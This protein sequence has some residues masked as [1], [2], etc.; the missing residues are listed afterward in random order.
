[1]LSAGFFFITDSSKWTY[2]IYCV[3]YRK[4]EKGRIT[5]IT[6][7]PAGIHD[8]KGFKEE[9][10]LFLLQGLDDSDLKIDS[11]EVKRTPLDLGKLNKVA[12]CVSTVFYHAYVILKI[13]EK[14]HYRY[15]SL[16]KHSD[17]LTIQISHKL[18]DV[19]QNFRG[20]PRRGKVKQI[21][22]DSGNKTIMCLTNILSILTSCMKY[23]IL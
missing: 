11:A 6:R 16:E 8:A 17:S 22:T 12:H 13:E 5:A 4:T 19:S 9:I 1:M 15:M 18:N 20:H 3:K 10:L 23:I 21:V 14:C 2:G 7:I